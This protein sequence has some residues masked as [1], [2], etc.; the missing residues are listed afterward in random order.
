MTIYIATEVNGRGIQQIGSFYSKSELRQIAVKWLDRSN[1]AWSIK[2]RSSV[3][4]ICDALHDQGPCFGA[5][6]HYRI[7]RKEA[8]F[9]QREGVE[10]YGF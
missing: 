3:S 5:R 7:S 8:L 4:D 10:T 2:R 9:L 1:K 6:S